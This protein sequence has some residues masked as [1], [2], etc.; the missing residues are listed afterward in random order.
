MSIYFVLGCMEVRAEIRLRTESDP[1]AILM[2]AVDELRRNGWHDVAHACLVLFADAIP[3]EG[4]LMHN[5]SL[6]SGLASWVVA[7]ARARLLRSVTHSC[8]THSRTF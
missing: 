5:G 7:G 2:R 1:Y 4:L 3:D 8:R 6:H